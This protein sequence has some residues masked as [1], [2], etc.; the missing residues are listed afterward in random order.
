LTVPRADFGFAAAGGKLYA[1]GGT[2][3]MFPDSVTGSV[4]EYDPSADTWTSKSPLPAPRSCRAA[5][6]NGK[7]YAVG[8]RLQDTS[9]TNLVE[10]YDPVFDRWISKAAMPAPRVGF[11][12]AVLNDKIYVV[13]GLDAGL[14]NSKP[15]SIAVY[16]PALDQ[17][18]ELIP[19]RQP[20]FTFSGSSFS[21]PGADADGYLRLPQA[22]RVSVRTADISGELWLFNSNFMVLDLLFHLHGNVFR[23]AFPIGILQ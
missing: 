3:R 9:F 14:D 16:D 2:Y 10:E 4:E 15:L 17:W 6:V 23:A 5:A 19:S 22:F 21:I 1:I 11:A 20:D 12:L 18:S 8:G 7:I 13:G